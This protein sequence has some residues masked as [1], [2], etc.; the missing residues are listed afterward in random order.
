M[1]QGK[2]TAPHLRQTELRQ[3]CTGTGGVSIFGLLLCLSAGLKPIITSSS[4]E[5]LRA[6]RK[7]ASGGQEIQT[8]NYKTT[9]KWEDE[10]QRLTSGKGADIFLENGGVTTIAQSL[11]SIGRRGHVSLIGFLG[12]WATEQFPDTVGTVLNKSATMR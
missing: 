6:I 11:A 10:I 7:L 3:F 5:K 4:D 12:G 1:L 9:P 8:V 2:T